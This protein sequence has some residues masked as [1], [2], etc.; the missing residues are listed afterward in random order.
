MSG[1][2]RKAI[3][4]GPVLLLNAEQLEAYTAKGHEV[5]VKPGDKYVAIDKNWKIRPDQPYATVPPDRYGIPLKTELTE[6]DLIW[7]Q[8]PMGKDEEML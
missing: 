4:N 8:E 3:F 1:E 7:G 6:D 2:H 5:V